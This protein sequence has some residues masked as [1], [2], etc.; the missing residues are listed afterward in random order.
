[1]AGALEEKLTGRLIALPETRELDLF[2]DML[3]RRGART[4]RCPLVRILD[5]PDPAPI[6][7]WLERCIAGE[8][9]DLILLTGEGLRRLLGVA[10]RAG[11]R[12]AF[13][14]AL[15][16]LRKIT[17][18]PKP[19][20]A[21]RDID[22][23]PDLAASEP[24]TDGIIHDLRQHDLRGR[25]V[26]VQLYGSDPNRRLLDFL[27][28]AGARTDPVAPYVYADAADDARVR[29]L[30][31]QLAAGAVDAIAFTSQ[32]QVRRLFEVAQATGMEPQLRQGFECSTVAAVGPVVAQVLRE[33]GV[34]VDLVPADS[35]FLKPLVNALAARLGP[36]RT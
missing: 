9:D 28:A 18:G 15:A 19:A 20:R 1:M 16:G 32:P 33:A 22:L 17:R 26:G 27:Q 8:L 12:E 31:A 11:R 10:E 25:R 21:L 30:I 5:A 34:R 4:L 36:A 13:V 14:Q 2:A 23:K 3:E 6:Q 35:F 24:T 7:A 29:E